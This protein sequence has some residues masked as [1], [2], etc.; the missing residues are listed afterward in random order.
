MLGAEARGESFAWEGPCVGAQTRGMGEITNRAHGPPECWE[1]THAQA[2][3]SNRWREPRT[4]AFR[5]RLWGGSPAHGFPMKERRTH[6]SSHRPL[7]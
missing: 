4:E 7:A 1:S 3:L 5:T 2:L 6:E